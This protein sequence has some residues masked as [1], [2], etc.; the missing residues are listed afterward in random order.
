MLIAVIFAV[1]VT[2]FLVFRDMRVQFNIA[3]EMLEVVSSLFLSGEI[4]E[5][6]FIKRKSQ[7][8]DKFNWYQ[9]H[10]YNKLKRN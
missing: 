3:I 9:R 6:T 8:T 1:L 10:L 5:D 2:I 4:D 7:I